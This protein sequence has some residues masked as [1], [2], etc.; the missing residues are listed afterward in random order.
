MPN[1]VLWML[2]ERII[3]G[4]HTHSDNRTVYFPHFIKKLPTVS[5]RGLDDTLSLEL[6][7]S[8]TSQLCRRHSTNWS[9]SCWTH[10]ID[11]S[12][13]VLS[14]SHAMNILSLEIK[15]KKK[16]TRSDWTSRDS[17]LLSVTITMTGIVKLLVRSLAHIT[18]MTQL[19][20][21]RGGTVYCIIFKG[22][23]ICIYK[24]GCSHI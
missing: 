23:R 8:C 21:F 17:I 3:G 1:P 4:R 13:K 10:A 11:L 20:A 15:V 14:P 22:R 2:W 12:I 24:R 7:S 6:I 19:I 9:N 18:W 5:R 16:S